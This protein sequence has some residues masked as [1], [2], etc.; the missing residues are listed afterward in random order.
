MFLLLTVAQCHGNQQ[1][2]SIPTKR[3]EVIPQQRSFTIQSEAS[4]S[5]MSD[6]TYPYVTY[7]HLKNNTTPIESLPSHQTLLM[8]LAAN[9]AADWEFLGRMLEVSETD[10]YAIRRDYRE[11][12]AE[13]T[14]QMLK[15]WLDTNGSRATVA[16]ISTAV[17][18][19][20][21]QYWNLLDILY[22]KTIVN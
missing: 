11:S 5:T 6:K 8:T 9:L 17:Y 19:S 14:V 10:I 20:G 2:T 13:Q 22:K 3:Y 18:E 21:L 7:S 16:V 1:V 4:C 12:T 15:K